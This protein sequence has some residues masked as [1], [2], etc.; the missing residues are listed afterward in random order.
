MSISVLILTKNEEKDIK[1]CLESVSWSDDIHV[2]DSYSTDNTVGIVQNTDAFIT[3]R[4]FDG[5]ASQRNYGL[6]HIKYKYSWL[7]ILDADERVP[8]QL[9]QNLEAFI[10]KMPA[11]VV[12]GRIRRRDFL[13]GQWLKH[14]QIS[15][16]YVRLV[17]PEKVRYDR[18]INEVL[19]VDGDTEDVLGYFDHYPFSKGIDH[20]LIKH[21]TYSHMEAELIVN[22]NIIEPSLKAALFSPD[23]NE[24]RLHQ[25]AFFYR[26]PA[27]PFIKFCYMM[28]FRLS[29]LDGKAGFTYACLQTIYE[30]FI[31]LKA[32]ELR[33][34]KGQKK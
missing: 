1:G 15:P 25:K 20:W 4:V 28:F 31:V 16:Y 21:N 24:R 9:L 10:A 29:F 18:E 33:L 2:L 19:L 34:N 5:Y 12:A 26:M 11:N 8:S 27:R 22:N 7:L 13:W 6:H 30:Y 32:Y 23:F 14:A 17:R 3:Q